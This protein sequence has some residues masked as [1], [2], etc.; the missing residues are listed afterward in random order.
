MFMTATVIALA[1][2]LTAQ[3]PIPPP[4]VLPFNDGQHW[5]VTAPLTYQ[6]GDSP[7]RITVPQ[8]FVTDFAS[9]PRVF[10]ALL[11]PTGRPGRGA[12]VHDYLY[13]EQPCTREQA[14]WILLL[15]M[16]ESGVD[17]V[18]R[19]LVY[20]VVDWFGAS[21]WQLNQ[22]E[23]MAGR[24]RVIPQE[25]LKIPALALWPPY[26]EDLFQK[27]VRPP[28]P[29]PAVPAYCAAAMT[30]TVPG[31]LGAGLPERLATLALP[32]QCARSSVDRAPAF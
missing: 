24:P 19:Q 6:I 9:I 12:I 2:P 4:V 18:T 8:G 14:D 15:A 27:G 25:F 32:T 1:I 26:R 23:R 13:W 21:A 17:V 22:Q 3:Q 30:I 20:K 28:Q 31:S 16:M 11:A 7:H 10:H 5:V 29:S